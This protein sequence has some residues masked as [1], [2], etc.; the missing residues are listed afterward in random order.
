MFIG[1]CRTQAGSLPATPV[2]CLG[3]LQRSEGGFAATELQ[4]SP[5]ERFALRP[6]STPRSCLFAPWRVEPCS[7]A[8]SYG[9][10]G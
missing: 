1:D 2:A 4:G 3:H 5:V 8:V 9:G 6:G 7:H 10:R